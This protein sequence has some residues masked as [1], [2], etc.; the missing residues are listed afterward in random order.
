MSR[1]RG[2]NH[3][4]T[5]TIAL[6]TIMIVYKNRQHYHHYKPKLF[7]EPVAGSSTHPQR[8]GLPRAQQGGRVE[9][10]NKNLINVAISMMNTAK[11]KTELWEESL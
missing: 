1:I 8:S 5:T 3:R 9:R 11:L 2:G 7:Y 4:Q 6:I 10:K